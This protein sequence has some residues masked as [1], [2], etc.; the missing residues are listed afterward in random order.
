MNISLIVKIDCFGF[1]V[2]L[3]SKNALT[4]YSVPEVMIRAMRKMFIEK[5]LK[6]IR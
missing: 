3:H 6:V 2:Y 5:S 4:A 1:S